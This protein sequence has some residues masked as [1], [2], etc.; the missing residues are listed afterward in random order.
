M[1]WV[2]FA[3]LVLLG[4]VL[5]A[6]NLLNAFA[7]GQ[8]HIRPSALIVLLVFFAVHCRTHEAIITSFVIGL[9]M[10][11]SGSQ[12]GPHTISYCLIGGLLN[13]LGEYFVLRREVS[14]AALIFSAYVIAAVIAYWLGA[15]KTGERQDY[16]YRIFVLT[17]LYSAF[18]GS[19]FWRFLER[20]NQPA[21]SQSLQTSPPQRGY[22]R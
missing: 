11:I 5:E 7:L 12:I 3:I 21:S 2:L 15:M 10:D 6:G 22:L 1:R 9:A 18:I 13:Q 8:W 16:A 4:A 20:I 14:P 19:F 17:G